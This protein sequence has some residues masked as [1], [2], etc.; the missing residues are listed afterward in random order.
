MVI[1]V[2]GP[3]APALMAMLSSPVWMKQWVMVTLRALPGSMASLCRWPEGKPAHILCGFFLHRRGLGH[4]A[5]RQGMDIIVGHM[6][7]HR[8]LQRQLKR[9]HDLMAEFKCLPWEP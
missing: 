4:A 7:S 5:R 3:G 2:V 1:W 9:A 8:A 6:P